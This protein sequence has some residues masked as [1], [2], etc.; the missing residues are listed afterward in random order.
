MASV[1]VLDTAAL[2]AWPLER[3]E[4]GMVLESQREELS[5]VAPDRLA[6]L[7]A[8]EVN[9]ASPGDAAIEAAGKLAMQ[10]GDI[11]GLSS[12]DLN[13][14][15][16]AMEHEAILFTDDYRLQNLCGKGGIPWAS[17]STRGISAI[18]SWEVRC[19]GCGV[20]QEIPSQTPLTKGDIGT[21]YVCG[22]PLRI[23]RKM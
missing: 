22:S 23:K 1:E 5:R 12:T 4:G 9:W 19:S 6:L 14:L 20:E 13:L 2:I 21:C 18:W 16:L 10:T 17:V 11:A 3:I 7:D 8:V 15:A